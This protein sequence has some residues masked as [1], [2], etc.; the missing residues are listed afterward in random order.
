MYCQV[1]HYAAVRV[2][3]AAACA[4]A[5]ACGPNSAVAVDDFESHNEA[6]W[7][8][9][10][11]GEIEIYLCHNAETFAASIYP[12]RYVL[13]DD[14]FGEMGHCVDSNGQD[15]AHVHFEEAVPT[16][17]TADINLY[18]FLWFNA[19]AQNPNV[20]IIDDEITLSSNCYTIALQWAN[21]FNTGVYDYWV[22][23]INAQFEPISVDCDDID[24][25][26]VNVGD[27][28]LY[29]LKVHAN[30]VWTVQDVGGGL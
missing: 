1:F 3:L 13:V 11:H 18:W 16:E 28:A 23:G 26:E 29:A 19:D 5:L 10:A 9:N 27:I 17:D 24:M 2:C 15:Y 21:Q 6:W 4:I 14:G 8:E 12:I 20:L 25:D 22:D 7:D 30:I